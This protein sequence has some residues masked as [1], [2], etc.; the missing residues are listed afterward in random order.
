MKP[1]RGAEFH[2]LHSAPS[3][4]DSHKQY[5]T[6][7]RGPRPSQSRVSPSLTNTKTKASFSL[8][9]KTKVWGRKGVDD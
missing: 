2:Y 4:T 9:M 6:T 8:N 3:I 1:Q 7:S 5:E